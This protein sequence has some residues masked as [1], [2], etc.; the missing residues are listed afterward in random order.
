MVTARNYHESLE[1]GSVLEEKAPVWRAPDSYGALMT[2]VRMVERS[3]REH[4]LKGL[5]EATHP[6]RSHLTA[7]LAGDLDNAEVAQSSKMLRLGDDR[8]AAKEAMDYAESA[9]LKEKMDNQRLRAEIAKAQADLVSAAGMHVESYADLKEEFRKLIVERD[10]TNKAQALAMGTARAALE[11][12]LHDKDE[13]LVE[14]DGLYKQL[15]ATSGR[16]T[17]AAAAAAKEAENLKAV[18]SLA[19]RKEAALAEEVRQLKEALCATEAAAAQ[20]AEAAAAALERYKSETGA[21]MR[22]LEE[23][24]KL[25]DES[26]LIAKEARAQIRDEIQSKFDKQ[27]RALLTE[28]EESEAKSAEM[29]KKFKL[30]TGNLGK[31]AGEVEQLR[32]ENARLARENKAMR[33]RE[34]KRRAKE[35]KMSDLAN[36][37]V[38][39]AAANDLLAARLK[40]TQKKLEEFTRHGLVATTVSAVKMAAAEPELAAALANQAGRVAADGGVATT[41]YGDGG[42]GG[43]GG[44]GY[45]ASGPFYAGGGLARRLPA[46]A[47]GAGTGARSAEFNADVAAKIDGLTNFSFASGLAEG[48]KIGT[49]GG[50]VDGP[51][52]PRPIRPLQAVQTQF[53]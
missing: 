45:A 27:L 5:L 25:Q 23:S 48:K 6:E 30:L 52:G 34:V 28:I 15:A 13:L 32:T 16:Q 42:G 20:S 53:I 9:L 3:V 24:L 40:D 31:G 26:E 29:A 18:R 39:E 8:R 4:Q 43:G 41:P 37:L 51:P 12:L 10:A 46:P 35:E 19:R 50:G 22:L 21:K 11:H 44:D 2:A 1:V 14:V 36:T 17:R 33:A 49:V 38:K 47:F 7:A